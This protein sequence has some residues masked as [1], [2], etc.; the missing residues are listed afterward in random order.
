LKLRS[1]IERVARGR[2][3]KRS[4]C[5]GTQRASIIVSPDAQL[6]YLKVGRN[7]FDKD[8]IEIAQH[9]LEPTDSVW[10][11]GAN[12]GVFSVA[13]AICAKSVVAVEADIWL[14]EIVQRTANL[15]E[16]SHL[17]IKVIPTAVSDT[18][19]IAKFKIAS[20][21]R[22]SN[23]LANAGGRSQ[24]GGVRE[25]VY[26]PTLNLD[27]LLHE[28]GPPD[29]IKIDVEGAEWM[30]VSGGVSLFREYDPIVYVEIGVDVRSDIFKFFSDAGYK[31]YDGFG[32]LISTSYNSS[33]NVFF[34][35]DKNAQR[36]HKL[37]E[38]VG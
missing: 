3:L 14:A 11:I 12:V 9:C 30:V 25:T 18:N 28:F 15:I 6:K 38:K 22:A 32:E 17:D 24:M 4:I 10:D 13:A 36:L 23:A 7:L 1:I 19:G 8:L 29:F 2:T 27:T 5:V 20:R 33:A 34:A 37:R 26:V 21:G 16:N 31:P 35:R